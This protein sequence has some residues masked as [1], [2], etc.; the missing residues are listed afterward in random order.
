MGTAFLFADGDL[1][2]T[3]INNGGIVPQYAS[4][5]NINSRVAPIEA[6]TNIWNTGATD[7]TAGTNY[8]ATNTVSVQL[9]ALEARS[10]AWNQSAANT[11]LSD[12]TNDSGYTLPDVAASGTG[13]NLSDYTNDS[14]YVLPD[15]AASG[16]G[17]NLSDY[18]N[19]S[20]YTLPDVA[21]S[22]TGTNLS[23]YTDD[24]G[25]ALDTDI[26]TN[27][28]NLSIQDPTNGI[29]YFLPNPFNVN[30]EL[31]EVFVQSHGM[32]GNVDIVARDRTT[33]WY[34]YNTVQADIVADADGTA[35]TSFTGDETWTNSARMGF[36]ASDLSAFATTNLLSVDFKITR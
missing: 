19:D 4:T 7:A 34:T 13:T 12:Y 33:A 22:G 36:V 29:A 2:I 25:F 23:D 6:R 32:T 21:G 5:A 31:V 3:E 18:T 9:T 14:G 30:V 24:V 20:G 27:V 16:T 17:T 8:I 11:N 35:Q 10:N 28:Y 15:V 26:A 1:V